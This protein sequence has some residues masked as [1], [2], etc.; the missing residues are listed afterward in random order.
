MPEQKK[1]TKS[2]QRKMTVKKLI[3]IATE[4]FASKGYAGAST[5]TI[6]QKVGLTRGALITILRTK[7]VCFLPYLRPPRKKS[8]GVWKKVRKKQRT[9]GTNSYLGAGHF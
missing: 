4:E 6:V 3:H 8:G 5:E 7:P 2:E 9:H 1:I